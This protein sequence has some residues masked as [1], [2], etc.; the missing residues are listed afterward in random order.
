M[1]PPPCSEHAFAIIA[2]PAR[3]VIHPIIS[4]ETCITWSFHITINLSRGIPSPLILRIT[5][6]TDAERLA[7]PVV[8]ILRASSGIEKPG[9]VVP[10][11]PPSR[12]SDTDELMN[13]PRGKDRSKSVLKESSSDTTGVKD[14]RGGARWDGIILRDGGRSVDE[15]EDSL[16]EWFC[17]TDADGRLRSAGAALEAPAA[18]VPAAA[19]GGADDK[20]AVN[21]L[22]TME[23]REVMRA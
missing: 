8:L 2:F 9:M 13:V 15:R 7:L 22:F 23:K 12:L 4:W 1:L 20:G 11:M 17:T 14:T 21:V 6:D 3:L 16:E 5:L 19:G 10:Y 18:V